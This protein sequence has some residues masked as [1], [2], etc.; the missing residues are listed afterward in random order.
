MQK[1]RLL[2][3]ADFLEKVVAKKPGYKFNMSRFAD[4]DF[5]P[6][7]CHTAACALGWATTIFK[8]LCLTDSGGALEQSLRYRDH[9]AFEAAMV[10]FGLTE[11]QAFRLF[12]AFGGINV[13]P[14]RVARNIRK[15]VSKCPQ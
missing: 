3:L 9:D 15:V 4:I 8:T 2:K 6:D 13:T 11:P 5:D 1:K 7:H 12:G 10:F 14:K